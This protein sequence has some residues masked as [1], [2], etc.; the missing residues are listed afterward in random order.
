MKKSCEPLLRWVLLGEGAG[1]CLQQCGLSRDV[2]PCQSSLFLPT[3]Q[4]EEQRTMSQA[5]PPACCATRR[6]QCPSW[7]DGEDPQAPKLMQNPIHC[8]E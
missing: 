7:G 5:A 6:A 2:P 3:Q 8:A 4:P 1:R